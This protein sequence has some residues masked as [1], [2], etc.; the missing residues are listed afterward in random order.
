MY[1]AVL[2][3]RVVH[4]NQLIVQTVMLLSSIETYQSILVSVK[5]GIMK[6]E[7]TFVHNAATNVKLVMVLT[8]IIAYLV[9]KKV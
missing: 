8:I 6:V 7:V 1:N 9:R 5:T 4:Y 3:V 2:D